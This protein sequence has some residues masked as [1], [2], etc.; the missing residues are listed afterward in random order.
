[1]SLLSKIKRAA[2]GD[3]KFTTL[4]HEAIRR[5]FASYSE[6]RERSGAFDNEP[7]NLKRPYS[8]MSA[9]G[10]LA[11]FKGPREAKFFDWPIAADSA[12]PNFG[13]NIEWRRDP[14][15]NYV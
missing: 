11:H 7:L 6:R 1:M 12:E 13:K 15:S 3:V 10:L 8:R 4:V 5:G 2:R 14:L 9:D